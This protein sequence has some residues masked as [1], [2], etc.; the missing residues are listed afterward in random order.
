MQVEDG[1][2]QTLF[3]KNLNVVMVD[4]GVPNANFKRF[5]VDSAQANWNAVRMIYKDGDP[6]LPIIAREHTCLFHWFASLDKVTQKVY[7][8]ILTI[9]TQT[10][11]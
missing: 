4:N 10:T 7:Q 3:W 9:S 5:M 6:S 11:I 8:T 2:A 1:A